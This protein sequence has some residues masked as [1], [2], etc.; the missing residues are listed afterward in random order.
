[1]QN[2]NIIPPQKSQNHPKIPP[3]SLFACVSGTTARQL[4]VSEHIIVDSLYMMTTMARMCMCVIV[5]VITVA[6][7]VLAPKGTQLD[8]N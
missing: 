7:I 6:V 5:C 2:E 3:I 4:C 1:M 8:T